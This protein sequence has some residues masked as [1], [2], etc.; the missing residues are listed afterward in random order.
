[1]AMNKRDFLDG[2]CGKAVDFKVEGLGTIKVKGLTVLA[3]KEI[4]ADYEQDPVGAAIA[5]L[6]YGVVEPSLDKDDLQ[7]IYQA[8]SGMVMKIAQRISEL[9]GLE[10]EDENS[11]N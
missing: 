8:N 3:T 7:A 9:S 1:M 5:T 2:I 6:L 4:Q 10:V 11:P